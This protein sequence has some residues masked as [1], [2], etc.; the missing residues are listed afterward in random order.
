M[1][2]EFTVTATGA[3]TDP[4][5]VTCIVEYPGDTTDSFVYGTDSEVEQ[6][7]TGIYTCTITVEDT[8]SHHYRFVGTGDCVAAARTFFKVHN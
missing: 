7:S 2:G 4:S 8:G 5:T 6:V 3:L 1:R